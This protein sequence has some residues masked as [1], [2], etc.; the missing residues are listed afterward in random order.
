MNLKNVIES[1]TCPKCGGRTWV[2][3]CV[4]AEDGDSCLVDHS[5]GRV[6][7]VNGHSWEFAWEEVGRDRQV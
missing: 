1:K 7:C 3:N 5:S 2:E 6:V 4:F